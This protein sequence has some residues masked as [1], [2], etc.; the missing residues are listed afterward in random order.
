MTVAVVDSGGANIAS[1]MHALRRLG[2]EARFTADAGLIRSADRVIL[3]G[4]GAAASA[5]RTLERNGL[6]EVIRALEQPVLGI[7]LGMQLLFEHTEEGNVGMLGVI[8]GNVTRLEEKPGLRV[9]NMGWLPL[10]S[11]KNHMLG[12]RLDGLW[13][14][15]V[16]SFAAETGPWSAATAEH[17]RAFSALVCHDNFIGAQFHPERSA[18]AGMLLLKAFLEDQN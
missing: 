17:G 7:C 12:D 9:P 6:V 15:F 5:M 10:C 2:V 16:H 8:P 13:F 3:P 1:V 18:F 11:T 4:V 14:Y